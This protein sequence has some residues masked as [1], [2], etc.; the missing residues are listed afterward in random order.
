MPVVEGG[1]VQLTPEERRQL[2][3]LGYLE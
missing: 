2:K 1:L 3:S